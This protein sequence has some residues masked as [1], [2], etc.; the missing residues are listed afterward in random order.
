[1]NI[2]LYDRELRE[3]LLPLTF[4]RPVSEL[5]TG[6]LTLREK[7]QMR[8]PG[9]YSWSTADYLAELFP[10][11]NSPDLVINGAVCATDQLAEAVMALK[12]GQSLVKNAVVLA[13]KGEGPFAC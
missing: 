12:P 9:N 2:L 6:I 4:T 7:W 8:I 10:G 13:E 3:H 11:N 1:M 5:R